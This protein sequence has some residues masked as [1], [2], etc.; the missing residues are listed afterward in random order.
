[1]EDFV[2]FIKKNSL[3]PE[4]SKRLNPDPDPDSMKIDP[5]HC[6]PANT[7]VMSTRIRIDQV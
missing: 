5:K 6:H 4:P 7:A 3:D 1:M 2:R